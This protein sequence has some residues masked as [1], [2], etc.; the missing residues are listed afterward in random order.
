MKSTFLRKAPTGTSRSETSFLE[1]TSHIPGSRTK[2][3]RSKRLFDIAFSLL[4]LTLICF[5]L[6]PLLAVLIKSSSRGPVFFRQL[7]HG[8]DNR[9]FYC[10]K[11]RTMVLNE[12]A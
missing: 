7:R 4:V 6:F 10:F 9:P 8:K 2:R 12:D 3:L 5:W 1:E 11:F